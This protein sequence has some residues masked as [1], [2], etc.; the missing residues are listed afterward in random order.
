MI[1]IYLY[2]DT[3][4]IIKIIIVILII[5]LYNSYNFEYFDENINLNNDDIEYINKLSE[6]LFTK[7]S[8]IEFKNIEFMTNGGFTG[9]IN[10]ESGKSVKC[11]NLVVHDILNT[12][13]T[14]IL[15]NRPWTNINDN[16]QTTELG[17]G[18]T[19]IYGELRFLP[20]NR[21]YGKSESQLW[22]D[23]RSDVKLRN[24]SGWS[25]LW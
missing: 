14:Y 19:K 22:N 25:D 17:S 21:T 20:T 18:R 7:K 5:Y 11:T 16:T 23:N 1:I 4:L 12:N 2:M 24:E 10:M 13:K 8:P 15:N 3:N 9:D 6:E